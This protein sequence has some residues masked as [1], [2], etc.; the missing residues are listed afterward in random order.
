MHGLDV[1]V[2]V[3]Q[4]RRLFGYLPGQFS[5]W[6][7]FCEDGDSR[8]VSIGKQRLADGPEEVEKHSMEEAYLAFILMRRRAEA[9]RERKDNE[10]DM[11]F[12]RS[13]A[14]SR[15]YEGLSAAMAMRAFRLSCLHAATVARAEI[16]S[17]LRLARTWVFLILAAALVVSAFVFYTVLH[18]RASSSIPYAGFIAPEYILSSLGTSMLWI[19]LVGTIFLAFDVRARDV[20]DRIHEVLDSRPVSN[21]ELLAGRLAGIALLL[22]VA[23][24]AVVGL[25]CVI[26]ASLDV[27][28]GWMGGVPQLSISFTFLVVDCLPAYLFFGAAMIFLAVALKLRLAVAMVGL[29]L[30]ATYVTATYITPAYLLPVTAVPTAFVYLPSEVSPRIAELPLLLQRAAMLLIASGLI[31]WSA[32]LFPRRED[33]SRMSRAMVGGVLIAVGGGVIAYIVL[34]ALA[35]QEQIR[36]WKNVHAELQGEAITDI[37]RIDGRIS[38]VPGRRLELDLQLTVKPPAGDTLLFTFNPG[39]KISSIQ[40]DGTKAPYTH[41]NGALQIS[42]STAMKDASMVVGLRASGTPDPNFAYLD[43][44]LDPSSQQH[45]SS[46]LILLGQESLIFRRDFVALMPGS[47]WLPASGT[48]M[49][50]M[51]PDVGRDYFQVDLTVEVPAGWDIAGPGLREAVSQDSSVVAYRFRPAAPLP[52]VGLISSKYHRASAV[53]EDIEFALLLDPDHLENLDFFSDITDEIKADLEFRVSLVKAFG[54]EYPYG[55]ITM[56]EVPNSLR[57]HGGGWDAPS[58]QALPGLLL[59]REHSL[60]TARFDRWQDP[61]EQAAGWHPVKN[62]K[63]RYLREYLAKDSMGGNPFVGFYKNCFSYLTSARGTGSPAIDHVTHLLS[64]YTLHGSSRRSSPD[65]YVSLPGGYFSAH[66]Y[67]SNVNTGREMI[68]QMWETLGSSGKGSE[69]LGDAFEII[70]PT[71]SDWSSATKTALAELDY[72]RN[73]DISIDAVQLRGHFIF[74]TLVSY[75]SK[76]GRFTNKISSLLA[77]LRN[78]YS[79]KTYTYDD[80]TT[81]AAELDMD[82]EE[83]LADWLTNSSLPGFIASRATG[84]RLPDSDNGAPRYQT[85]F[86]VY[87]GEPASGVLDTIYQEVQLSDSYSRHEFTELTNINRHESIQINILSEAPLESIRIRP[88]LSLNRMPFDAIVP[89]KYFPVDS[90]QEATTVRNSGWQPIVNGLVVDDLDSGFHIQSVQ[91]TSKPGM[92]SLLRRLLEAK[93]Q[94]D[95]GLPKYDQSSL[96]PRWSREDISFAWGKYRRTLAVKSPGTPQGHVEFKAVLP[97]AGLWR[98]QNHAP[99]SIQGA[100]ESMQRHLVFTPIFRFWEGM[101]PWVQF[102]EFALRIES[103][104]FFETVTFNYKHAEPGWNTVGEFELE[105]GEVTVAV[106]PGW[107]AAVADAVRWIPV[108]G[109]EN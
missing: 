76:F 87:N 81:V 71:P 91:S 24:L 59:L 108:P 1:P 60:P 47:H 58:V 62:W 72:V 51:H 43:S 44:P 85:S 75:V 102:G 4:V 96:T 37:E 20:R 63:L 70:T 41:D 38:M 104:N 14:Y 66:A 88:Y 49:R 21:L 101:P 22:W 57:V 10:M 98:L 97:S 52:M 67:L 80:L 89:I 45:S 25:L 105:A 64:A 56:A 74:Q 46:A 73:P 7:I 61:G 29:S 15:P 78:R 31:L 94:M 77:E 106:I 32:A 6:C 99:K 53:V 3:S 26:G 65:Y 42:A 39:L 9:A 68:S 16:R 93:P 2:E 5:T 86:H 17:A 8:F 82:L 107:E 92:V 103:G 23:T 95:G 27:F 109:A 83:I 13:A 84:V 19:F 30:M 50:G 18:S 12:A 11:P 40:I 48:A 33:T 79:G 55:G 28:T 69:L 34:Q 100:P 36:H 35:T 90:G 54:L